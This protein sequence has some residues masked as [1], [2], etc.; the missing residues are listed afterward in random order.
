MNLHTHL[1]PGHGTR[2]TCQRKQP[3]G[4]G[5]VF[6]CLVCDEEDREYDRLYGDRGKQPTVAARRRTTIGNSEEGRNGQLTR[7]LKLMRAG[8][9][10]FDAMAEEFDVSPRTI[11]RD[12]LAMSDAGIQIEIIGHWRKGEFSISELPPKRKAGGK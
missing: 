8:S 6:Q 9:G 7:C 10:T 11:F 2:Y 3:C 1:C 5:D 4:G 12:C